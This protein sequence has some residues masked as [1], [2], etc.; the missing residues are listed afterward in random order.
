MISSAFSATDELIGRLDLA[1]NDSETVVELFTTYS[2]SDGLDPDVAPRTLVAAFGGENGVPAEFVRPSRRH[3]FSVT[4]DV[5]E[6]G[7]GR[8]MRR[9]VVE[10]VRAP[11]LPFRTLEWSTLG[12]PPRVQ[13]GAH[14]VIPPCLGAE[15]R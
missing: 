9:A 11:E 6:R 3:V 12:A 13:A 5:G 7:H 8:S 15:P 10:L 14:G 1:P 2:R 4:A